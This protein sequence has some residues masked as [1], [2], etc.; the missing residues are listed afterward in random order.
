MARRPRRLCVL[1][2]ALFCAFGLLIVYFNSTF[3]GS[4]AA[5]YVRQIDSNLLLQVHPYFLRD[6]LTLRKRIQPKTAPFAHALKDEN[7]HNPVH[8]VDEAYGLE[9][10]FLNLTSIPSVN[11]DHLAYLFA[12]QKIAKKENDSLHFEPFPYLVRPKICVDD[13]PVPPI[14]FYV[15]VSASPDEIV[16][17]SL[18][19]NTWAREARERG[20][21]V[22]FTMGRHELALKH[23][24]TSDVEVALSENALYGDILMAN[25]RDSWDHLI[26]KWWSTTHFHS[27]H[28]RDVRLMALTD[29]DTVVFAQNFD[30]FLVK[31]GHRFH[32][33]IGCTTLGGQP[34]ERGK[35]SRYYVSEQQWPEKLLPFYCSG[36]MQ[37]FSS[38]TA[39]RLSNGVLELGI[40]YVTSFKIFDVVTGP[41]A[42][43]AK[44]ELSHVNEIKSWLPTPDVCLGE[45][46][47]QHGIKPATL[48]PVFL[49]YRM[50]CCSAAPRNICSFNGTIPEH[51]EIQTRAPFL[52]V[53]LRKGRG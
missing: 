20:F 34:A 36:T 43:I 8:R 10:D 49:D 3:T 53:P 11:D 13:G 39:R 37:I 14:I 38:E 7:V 2:V 35:E 29:A 18:I 28:C 31:N 42:K 22:I 33:K 1:A 46:I 44:V 16:T 48:I 5:D 41:V 25:F 30:R 23:N 24:H 40:E 17:R 32:D 12:V 19:R 26:H 51:I 52:S 50:R 27:E 6:I 21:G 45:I 4:F 9:E 47:A 15:T